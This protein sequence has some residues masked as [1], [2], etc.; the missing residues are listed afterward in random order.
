MTT[1]PRDHR[2]RPNS[3]EARRASHTSERLGALLQRLV[4]QGFS[5]REAISFM[6]GVAIEKGVELGET[7]T[8]ADHAVRTLSDLLDGHG[9]KHWSLDAVD[10]AISNVEALFD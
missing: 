5:Q 10:L 3:L 2:G 1:E 4:E 8:A 6:A 7:W 9:A